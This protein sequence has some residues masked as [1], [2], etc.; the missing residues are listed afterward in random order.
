VRRAAF[1]SVSL[2]SL[3]HSL[4]RLSASP[5][6][7]SGLAPSS[8]GDKALAQVLAAGERQARNAGGGEGEQ[9]SPDVGREI[10]LGRSAVPFPV[11]SFA[12]RKEGQQGRD[13]FVSC[14]SSAGLAVISL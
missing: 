3:Y 13:L 14:S 9:Q 12:R 4:G 7:P 5:S 2:G 8:F 11:D 6:L 1:I 10:F